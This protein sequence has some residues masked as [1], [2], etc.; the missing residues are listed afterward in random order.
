MKNLKKIFNAGIL[1]LGM[2]TAAQTQAQVIPNTFF[3]QN[4]WMP[5]TVGSQVLGGKLHQSWGAIRDSKAQVI[6]FGGISADRERPT[7]FQYIKMIDSVRAKGME[8]VIQVSYHNG[9]FSAQQAAEVV[10]YLNVTKGKGI[11][12]FIIG[13][14][15]DLEY[16]YTTAAQ[17]AAYI[18]P[19]AT[20]MKAVDPSILTIGPETAW[21]D[22]GII[23]GLTT[24]NGPYDVTGRDANGRFYLDVISFHTYPFNGTQSRDQV[25]TELTKTGGLQDKLDYLNG[26]LDQCNTAHSRS[27]SSALK[28]AVT[29]M[30]IGYQNSASDN[31]NGVGAS[32]F[33]GGQFIAE[34]YGIG[35][36]KGVS[37][38]NIW[39]VIEGNNEQ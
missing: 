31:V 22:E 30:N 8:P 18:K 25:I 33:I 36:K 17:V 7:N 38:M 3:G 5:D 24:P 10:Q 14:E 20:A 12:Y 2:F 32:S 19:F 15:P 35:M 27:G 29:E 13:N 21:F 9:K 39:S 16:S 37:M 4:A 34:M 1:A 6:R 23:N 11:K 28:S 26:R